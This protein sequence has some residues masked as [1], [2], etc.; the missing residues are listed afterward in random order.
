MLQTFR[1]LE[2]LPFIVQ[3]MIIVA[4]DEDIGGDPG[5]T[6]R[7]IFYGNFFLKLISV[8]YKFLNN[9]P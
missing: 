3:K 9:T 7:G 5:R 8:S 2:V 1:K 4:V 6:L